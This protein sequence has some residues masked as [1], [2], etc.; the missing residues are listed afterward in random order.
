MLD[1]RQVLF[2]MCYEGL[3]RCIDRYYEYA[4]RL[5]NGLRNTIGLD[6]FVDQQKHRLPS[7]VVAKLPHRI[8]DKR[9]VKFLMDR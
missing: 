4:K 2:L 9:F 3:G 5:Q 1:M 7:A 8:N 6:L